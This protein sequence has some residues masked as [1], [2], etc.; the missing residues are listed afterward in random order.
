MTTDFWNQR[1]TEEGWAYG[2]A[3]NEFFRRWLAYHK[4][5]R[6][7]LPCEGEGRQALHAARN[8]WQVEAFD[9]S[10][11]GMNKAMRQAK[12]ENLDLVFWVEDVLNYKSAPVFDGVALIYA[13]LPSAVRRVAHRNLASA[14]LEGG[15]LILEGFHTDQVGKPSGGPQQ[16]PDMLFQPDLLEED[17]QG[18]EVLVNQVL[19][20]HLDEGRYHRG[21]ASICRFIARKPIT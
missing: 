13:H 8:G 9:L 5:G 11:A 17:F 7:L 15:W 12:L 16:Q 20:T 18:M 14:V 2:D 3:P 4:P 6:L 1:Y 10:E 19:H 21:E